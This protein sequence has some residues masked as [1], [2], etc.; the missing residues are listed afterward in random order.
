MTKWKQDK[1]RLI[2]Q[3]KY[4]LVTFLRPI[5]T[6]YYYCKLRI[7]FFNSRKPRLFKQSFNPLKTRRNSL[8]MRV[9]T[10]V[11]LAWFRLID[12]LSFFL[13]KAISKPIMAA[14]L[15]GSCSNRALIVLTHQVYSVI[16][17]HSRVILFWIKQWQYMRITTQHE[18]GF[19]CKR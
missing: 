6:R 7:I 18:K 14:A 9:Q 3:C 5:K 17:G 16:Q 8:G 19:A 10:N 12:W 4:I 13:Y 11:N 15:T 2:F 1:E